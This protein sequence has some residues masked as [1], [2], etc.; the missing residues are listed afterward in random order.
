LKEPKPQESEVLISCIE[1][2]RLVS[3]FV[4][5]DVDP[6]L[7]RRMAAHF[8]HCDH[9]SAILDGTRNVLKLVGD[10]RAF[11]VPADLGRKIYGKL[12]DYLNSSR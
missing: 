1:V 6:D 10:D 5:G 2:F 3:S 4:D 11:E 9:C 8:E 12:D 7:K